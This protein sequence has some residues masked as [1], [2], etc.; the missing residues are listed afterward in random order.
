MFP[1]SKQWFALQVRPRFERQVATILRNKGY[2]EFLPTHEER[3]KKRSFASRP[4]FPGYLFCRVGSNAH[5]FVVTTPG[6]IRI[7]GFG[8]KPVPIDVEEIHS[9]QIVVRSG[10]PV[11]TLHGFH[12]GDKVFIKEGPL[13]GAAGVLTSFRSRERFVVT[14]TMMMRSVAA[15][16]HAACVTPLN[17][18][19][20]RRPAPVQLLTRTA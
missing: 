18:L 19:P 15:E 10:L 17:P 6:V 11:T 16:V 7:V 1:D 20:E 3:T 14:I 12:P 13:S 5:G 8:G 2:E 9:L 4:L